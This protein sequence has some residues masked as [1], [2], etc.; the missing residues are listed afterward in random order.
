M[1][2]KQSGKNWKGEVCYVTLDGY[3]H[4]TLSEVKEVVS[5]KDFDYV[6]IVSG[7]P[8]MGKSNFAITCCKYL[9]PN[10]NI[11]SIA[12]TADEFIQKSTD[13]PPRSAIMLDESFASLNSKVGRSSDF[14]R[15]LNHLQIIRQKNHYIFLCL[16]NFFDLQ[17]SIS[18][19]RSRHL[20]VVYGG[21]FGTRGR[22]VAFGKDEKRLLYIKGLKF[23]D[24]NCVPSNYYG[25]FG[26]QKSIDHKEYE[27]KKLKHLLEQNKKIIGN[28]SPV[29]IE[30]N[31]LIFFLSEQGIKTKKIAEVA[32]MELRNIQTI[33]K[34]Q[35]ESKY[36][37]P[38]PKEVS[39]GKQVAN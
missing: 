31:N 35:K 11:D 26:K 23:M 27:S 34:S 6:A 21:D 33:I 20:F 37:Y 36:N 30:R 22:F 2:V 1:V 39:I 12:M 19:Y 17:K 24:Y 29:Y 5:K 13:L 15:I 4:R 32:Q 7:D 38:Y 18:I 16:P 25:T 8:G 14:L 28:K 10:F 3:L 9:D